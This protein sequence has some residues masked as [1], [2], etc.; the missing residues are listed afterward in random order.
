MKLLYITITS[1]EDSRNKI[2]SIPDNVKV[3]LMNSPGSTR[4]LGMIVLDYI[5]KQLKKEFYNIE[6]IILNIE[7]DHVAL[8]TAISLKY[9]NIIY[10]GN[11]YQ[12]KNLI[13]NHAIYLKR[14]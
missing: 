14:K 7:D 5:F 3:V 10:N 12:A 6:K 2:K 11:S 1:L 9:N 4:Y 13:A 8:Y